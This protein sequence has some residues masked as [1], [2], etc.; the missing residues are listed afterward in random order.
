LQATAQALSQTPIMGVL[1]V[2]TPATLLAAD[3]A[4]P[5]KFWTNI[6]G[7]FAVAAF[8]KDALFRVWCKGVVNNNSAGPSSFAVL[9]FPAGFRPKET[10][11]F[12]VE[13]NG[14]TAQF[15]SVSPTGLVTPEVAVASLGSLDLAFSFL[16]EQ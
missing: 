14:A 8:Y 4:A 13:G 2:W 11:R 5:Q 6:G 3:A 16:A 7:T 9:Q 12:S 15:V 10:Q 1:P